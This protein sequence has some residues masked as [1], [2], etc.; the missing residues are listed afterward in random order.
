MTTKTNNV[1]LY[2][3]L[4]NRVRYYNITFYLNLFD[5]Y[6]LER[7]YGSTK[8]KTPTGIKR[9][10]HT[11]LDA[12]MSATLKKIEEKLNKGYRD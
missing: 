11:T 1:T 3:T 9:E 12:V 2:R 7:R 6:I 8:N 5:E 4:N 10:F